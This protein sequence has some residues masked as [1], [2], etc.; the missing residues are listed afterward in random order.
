LPNVFELCEAA[1][2][3]LGGVKRSRKARVETF[4]KVILIILHS[5]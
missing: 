3:G 1:E 2:G 5:L 4:G